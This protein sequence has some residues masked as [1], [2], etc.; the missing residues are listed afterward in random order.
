MRFSNLG[1]HQIHPEGLLKHRF[2]GPTTRISNSGL[3]W[4]RQLDFFLFLFKIIF[5]L[6]YFM[7][8]LCWVFIVACGLSLVAAR[9]LLIVVASV[10][11][12]HRLQGTWASE[13]AAH[14]FSGSTTCG[15]FLDQGWNPYP[16]L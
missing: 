8:W 1:R 12:E 15:V 3:E 2:Q 4:T 5:I 9:R 10:V 14:W 16:M 11:A 7:Y 6:F 13:V